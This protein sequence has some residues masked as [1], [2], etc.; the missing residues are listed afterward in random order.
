RLTRS[1]YEI[2]EDYI[3]AT[4]SSLEERI[5][6]SS[7]LRI[8]IKAGQSE[9]IGTNDFAENYMSVEKRDDYIMF[10]EEKDPVISSFK[11]DDTL[12]KNR[13]KNSTF[14]FSNEVKIIYPSIDGNTP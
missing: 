7:A 3:N 6:L 12:I 1:F 11:K 2:T 8:Y 10:C 13:I 5:D 4:S 9:I 14:K